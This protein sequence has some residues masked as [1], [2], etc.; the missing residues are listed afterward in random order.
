MIGVRLNTLLSLHHSAMVVVHALKPHK[1]KQLTSTVIVL[2]ATG[3]SMLCVS[4]V[5]T[6][7]AMRGI[8]YFIPDSP[9]VNRTLAH[10]NPPAF[11]PVAIVVG[12]DGVVVTS[13]S[14]VDSESDGIVEASSTSIAAGSTGSVV[15]PMTFIAAGSDG[16]VVAS[17]TFV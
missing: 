15:A 3:L 7:D 1:F 6:S 11:V 12:L 5:S 10:L 8:K 14:S 4:V 17:T 16:V 9:A 13:T 2:S